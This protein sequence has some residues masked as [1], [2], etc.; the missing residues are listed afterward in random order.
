MT[1]NVSASGVYLE[2]KENFEVGQIITLA[3]PFKNE[4]K[5]KI[6]GEV[7]WSNGRGFGIRFL[8]KVKNQRASKLQK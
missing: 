1:K 6:K 5:L 3:L 7:V 4:K 8:D 2:A